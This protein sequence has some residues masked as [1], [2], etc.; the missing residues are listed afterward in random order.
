[1]LGGRNSV[2]AG[3]SLSMQESWQPWCQTFTFI[4]TTFSFVVYAIFQVCRHSSFVYQNMSEQKK[5]KTICGSCISPGEGGA[6]R[7]CREFWLSKFF[8]QRT[9]TMCRGSQWRGWKLKNSWFSCESDS[10]VLSD[11]ALFSFKSFWS[12]EQFTTLVCD[13]PVLQFIHWEGFEALNIKYPVIGLYSGW[14]P[15]E[16][17]KMIPGWKMRHLLMCGNIFAKAQTSRSLLQGWVEVSLYLIDWLFHRC[18]TVLLW[19]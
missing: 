11:C 18:V 6:V 8:R 12:S 1:M 3:D 19:K 4:I 5:K 17:P 14:Q 16:Q 9:C 7:C 13:L 15:M 2:Q 10:F